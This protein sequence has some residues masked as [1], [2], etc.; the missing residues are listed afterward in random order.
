MPPKKIF[1]QAQSKL[2]TFTHS[3]LPKVIKLKQRKTILKMDFSTKPRIRNIS[4]QDKS[5]LSTDLRINKLLP[6]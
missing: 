2:M 6:N 5:E 4:R 1:D 3:K